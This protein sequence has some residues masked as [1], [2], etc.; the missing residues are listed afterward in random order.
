MRILNYVLLSCLVLQGC[1]ATYREQRVVE[2]LSGTT[3]DFRESAKVLLTHYDMRCLQ[4]AVD[5]YSTDDPRCHPMRICQKDRMNLR[6]EVAN[7]AELL[8]KAVDLLQRG[9]LET[10]FAILRQATVF[11]GRLRDRAT[12]VLQR[13]TY[14]M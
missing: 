7:V 10:A 2:G 11:V 6:Q 9:D 14:F 13:R 1:A 12:D 5:C 4:L 3:K 8:D